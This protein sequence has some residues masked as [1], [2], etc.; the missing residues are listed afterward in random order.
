MTVASGLL[1]QI[2]QRSCPLRDPGRFFADLRHSRCVDPSFVVHAD[3]SDAP[4]L[5]RHEAAGSAPAP[6]ILVAAG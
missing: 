1:L 5:E 3:L 4:A 2:G 6:A